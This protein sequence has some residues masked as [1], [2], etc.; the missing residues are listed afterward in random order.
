[1]GVIK[2]STRKPKMLNSHRDTA[3]ILVA[4]PVF[5]EFKYVDDVLRAVRRH[6]DNI[7]VVDDGSTD[8]TSDVL[9]KHTYI[10][11]V[12][13]KTNAGYGQSLIDAFDF[14]CHHR[15]DWVITIDCDHQHEPSYIPRFYS[16]IEKNDA[17]IISGSRFLRR[18]NLGS[19][20]LPADR[21]A[22]NRKITNILNQ[23]LAVELTDAFCG[24]K[25]Y[26]TKAIVKVKLTE[27]GY[28]LPL[29]L[30]IHASRA[31]LRI[32][33]IPVPLIYHDPKRKFCG[34]LEDPQKR[35]GYYI[36]IIERELGYNVGQNITKRFH[37][38]R[39]RHYLCKP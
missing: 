24:F 1:M 16:E 37:S 39:E 34:I 10:E 32:R 19:A 28:G 29:Q 14:A 4:I 8:G 20:P 7:L 11:V 6:T 30:W 17:D 27:G 5:N 23:N 31:G 35:L 15:F 25:A 9:K 21:V 18:I 2:H 26:R 33:E 38:Q 36:E 3:A 13:H 12:S 22:I